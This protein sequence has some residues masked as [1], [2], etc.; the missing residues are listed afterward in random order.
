MRPNIG[1]DDLELLKVNANIVELID[2]VLYF[3][4]QFTSSL[5]EPDAPKQVRVASIAPQGLEAYVRGDIIAE[6][7]PFWALKEVVHRLC[8]V[9]GILEVRDLAAFD[10]LVAKLVARYTNDYSP[11]IDLMN[12]RKRS[13]LLM[14]S[15]GSSLSATLRSSLVS[16]A[17]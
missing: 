5:R 4:T 8:V 15:P 1:P 2:E 16:S 6:T 12:R 14:N 7:T 10:V 3:H 11:E 17:R 13:S 9:G